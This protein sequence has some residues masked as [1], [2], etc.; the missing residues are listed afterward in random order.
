[1]GDTIRRISHDPSIGFS[2]VV[3]FPMIPTKAPNPPTLYEVAVGRFLTGW[4]FFVGTS[5]SVDFTCDRSLLVSFFF[6]VFP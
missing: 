4:D 3:V 1:M 6:L 5:A 2:F